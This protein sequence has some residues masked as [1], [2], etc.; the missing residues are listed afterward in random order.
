MAIGE[1]FSEGLTFTEGTQSPCY[2]VPEVI[3]F[4]VGMIE[5]NLDSRL[6]GFVFGILEN[7]VKGWPLV[8]S[9]KDGRLGSVYPNFPDLLDK[10]FKYALNERDVEIK[11]KY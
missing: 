5:E 3:D 1:H 6:M 9:V 2:A 10:L 4:C 7:I 11:L 8:K